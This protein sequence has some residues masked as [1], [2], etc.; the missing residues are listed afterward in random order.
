MRIVLVGPPNGAVGGVAASVDNLE[1][2]LSTCKEIAVTRILWRDLWQVFFD[3]PDVVHLNFTR[4]WKRFLGALICHLAKVKVVHTVHGSG[5]D[6]DAILNKWALKLTDGVV[7]LNKKIYSDFKKNI[8]GR[9]RV[10]ELTAIYREGWVSVSEDDVSKLKRYLPEIGEV[11]YVLVYAHSRA[12]IDGREVYGFEFVVRCILALRNIGAR[13]VF[14]DPSSA[15]SEYLAKAAFGLEFV[16]VQEPVQFRALCRLVDLYLR[17][18]STD[19]DSVAIREALQEGL[20]VLASDVVPRCNGVTLYRY[21][22]VDSFVEKV[23]FL[24]S[25]RREMGGKVSGEGVLGRSIRDYL[26]FV[27]QL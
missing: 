2:A 26:D 8:V 7:V 6:F 21:G 14:L 27:S 18:T 12:F 15:Y 3:R 9:P 22:D 19:G 24:L 10:V 16:H 5:F 1:A 20:A 13:V 11:K 25:A 23:G 4:P 17:P